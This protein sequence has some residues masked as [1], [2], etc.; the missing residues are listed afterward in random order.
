MVVPSQ[1]TPAS[2]IRTVSVESTKHTTKTNKSTKAKAKSKKKP[3]PAK[4]KKASA[5]KKKA[6]KSS[7][8]PTTMISPIP[9]V[10]TTSFPINVNVI[11]SAIIDVPSAS[12]REFAITNNDVLCGRGGLTNHHPGNILFR[13]LVKAKQP[14]YV[15]ATKREKSG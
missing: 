4:K 2:T 8:R 6:S 3:S 5:K 1:P 7:S 10:P 11:S 15:R 9:S 12:T 14:A 13:N